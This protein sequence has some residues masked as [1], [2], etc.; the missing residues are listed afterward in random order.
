MDREGL[1]ETGTPSRKDDGSNL[2]AVRRAVKARF[3]RD[4][5]VT[6]IV[7]LSVLCRSHVAG[8]LLNQIVYWSDR[9]GP[10]GEF[11]KSGI[12]WLRELGISRDQLL[13]ALERLR[14]AAAKNGKSTDG[15]GVISTRR[16]RI[17]TGAVVLY[18]RLELPK[19][20]GLIA[21]FA[22]YRETRLSENTTVAPDGIRLLEN[23]RVDSRKIPKSYKE[24]GLLT[25]TTPRITHTGSVCVPRS[26]FSFDEILEYSAQVE[27]IKNP[28]GL[29]KTLMADGTADSQIEKFQARKE[30]AVSRRS[31]EADP[32]GN[33]PV[34][35][36]EFVDRMQ[37]RLAPSDWRTWIKPIPAV[38]AINGS[39]TITVPNNIFADW[40]QSTYYADVQA[41]MAELN[42]AGKEVRFDFV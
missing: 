42:L 20:L 21:E 19:L 31:K 25:K 13:G 38:I 6:V 36:K 4:D 9:S 39:V 41:V 40:I 35:L 17:G 14:A 16:G 7:T 32:A 22:D 28:G 23:E 37:A 11:Y 8:L 26:R 29:A 12:D 27:G 5:I 10:L 24:H 34:L 18:Y 33:D 3:G 2:A 30:L 1:R 15:L